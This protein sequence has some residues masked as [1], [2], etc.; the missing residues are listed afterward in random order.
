MANAPTITIKQI[1]HAK[2][3]DRIRVLRESKNLPVRWL[4]EQLNISSA[5]MSDL[6][7]GRRNWTQE[8]FESAVKFIAKEPSK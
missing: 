1:D 2:A 3:G 8:R 5:F 7:R 4:A 6:E